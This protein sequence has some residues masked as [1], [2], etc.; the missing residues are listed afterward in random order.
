MKPIPEFIQL[1]I[2]IGYAVFVFLGI[3]IMKKDDCNHY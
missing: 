2:L 3:Y 1:V